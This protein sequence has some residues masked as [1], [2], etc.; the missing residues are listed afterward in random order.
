MKKNSKILVTGTNGLVG[1]SI[2]RILKEQNYRNLYYPTRKEL[3][4][5]NEKKVKNYLEKTKPEYV[6]SPAAY[7]G[8]I[9]ANMKDPI[10]FLSLNTKLQNNIIL[11]CYDSGVNNFAFFGSSCI[12]PK[13]SKQPIKEN[14]LLNGKLELTNEAYAVAKISGLKLC[15]YIRKLSNKNYFTVI[16][17]I[18]NKIKLAKKNNINEIKLY[19]TGKA[20]R[21]FLYVDDLAKAA[22]IAMKKNVKYSM[23]NVGSGEEITINKLA[24]LILRISDYRAKIS[25]DSKVPDGTPRKLLNSDRIKSLGWK[26]KISLIKGIK[27]TYDFLEKDINIRL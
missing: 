2:L 22:I 13:Y 27:K 4:L 11:S 20:K 9:E 26:P 25:F 24:K 6:F 17:A 14:E 23:I 16:P 10:N 8:G 19:G 12:Y 5:L 15:S 18:L 21:E 3:D 7:V 1:A